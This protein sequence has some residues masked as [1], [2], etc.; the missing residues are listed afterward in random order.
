MTM[1]LVQCAYCRHMQK[2]RD[3]DFCTAFP[4]GEGIPLEII[5]GLFDHRK[6]H[7]GDHGIQFAALP[8][9]R[10]PLE[11]ADDE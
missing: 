11:D 5:D 1:P 4:D 3:G 8:G 9:A 7:E 6:P 10:H 2:R